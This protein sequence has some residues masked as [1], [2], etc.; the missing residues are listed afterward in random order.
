MNRQQ[1]AAKA[2]DME[3]LICTVDGMLS[4]LFLV[5][6]TIQDEQTQSAITNLAVEA[7]IR[8]DSVELARLSLFD[9]LRGPK[10]EVVSS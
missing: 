9:Y 2:L 10:L 4:A 5:G 3:C 8:L 7:Q 6:Q 1:A